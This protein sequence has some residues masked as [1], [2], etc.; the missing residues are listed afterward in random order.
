GDGPAAPLK[1]MRF[2]Q[3]RTRPM[4]RVAVMIGPRDCGQPMRLE[5]FE[6]AEVQEGY[7]YEL[8]RGVID[9]SDIPDGPHSDQC[10]VLRDQLVTYKVARPDEIQR[11]HTGS[12]C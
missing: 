12:E 4:P 5:D 1:R 7:R 2:G 11:L 8:S 3:R 9:V 6:F 10:D